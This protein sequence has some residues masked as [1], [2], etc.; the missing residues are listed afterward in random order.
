MKKIGIWIRVSTLDQKRGDSPEIHETR[1]RAYAESKGWQVVTVYHLE[2]ISGKAIMQQKE[3]E[4]MLADIK[5][6]NIDGLIFSKLAR[7]ARNTREL[8]AFADIFDEHEASMISLQESIDTSTP[9]GRLFYTII[10]AMAQWEREETGERIQASILT[11][12]SMGKITAGMPSFGFKIVDAQL[13]IDEQEAPIRKLMYELFLEHKRR[14]TVARILNERGYVTRKGN[15]FSDMTVTRLLKKSDAKGIK[16]SNYTCAKSKSNPTGLKPKS[17]WVFTPCHAIVS[18]GLWDKVNAII[19]EQ[20]QKSSQTKPLNQRVHLFTSYLKCDKGHKMSVQSKTSKYSCV[21]CK[22]RI[23]QTDLEEVF[24]S[25][26]TEF[27]VSEDEIE[28]YSQSTANILQNKKNEFNTIK[29]SL[30]EIE[31]KMNRLLELNIEGQIPTKGFNNHYE[32][33]FEQ[34]EKLSRSKEKLDNEIKEMINAHSS[35]DIIR[36]ESKGIYE[37]WFSLERHEKRSIIEAIT[38]EI[39]FDGETIRFKLKQIAPLSSLKLDPNAQ[40]NGTTWLPGG[41]LPK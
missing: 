26:L 30:G 16:K 8:L 12:R 3:A 41:R 15:K 20:E 24:H 35:L 10:S 23:D 36:K 1:A 31:I 2:G 39:I 11:R 4:R 19:D 29:K 33:L 18:E 5:S 17:E 38:D 7:L 27:I 22:T 6:K 40:H 28:Q 37:K 14:A 34:S 13:E 9:A 32:P 25:R 21:K